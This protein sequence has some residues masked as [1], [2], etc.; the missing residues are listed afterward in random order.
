MYLLRKVCLTLDSIL[1]ESLYDRGCLN[2]SRLKAHTVM[3][4]ETWIFVRVVLNLD[5]CF[6]NA[7][8]SDINVSLQSFQR[9]IKCS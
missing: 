6:S 3:E 9:W 2:R 8:M 1:K 7:I 4:D 5:V